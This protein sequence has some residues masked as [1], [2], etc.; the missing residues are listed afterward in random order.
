M[1]VTETMCSECGEKS[2]DP[3][4]CDYC[5][6]AR[7]GFHDTAVTSLWLEV[8]GEYSTIFSGERVGAGLASGNFQVSFRLDELREQYASR[9]IYYASV[10]GVVALSPECSADRLSAVTSSLKSQVYLLEEIHSATGAQV[11]SALADSVKAFVRKPLLRGTHGEHQVLIYA[12]NAGMTLE[13]LVDLS[14][15]Q[16]LFPQV[17][18]AFTAVLE[19]M[20]NLHNAGYL[21]LKL[22]P[23]N[24]RIFDQNAHDGFPRVFLRQAYAESRINEDLAQTYTGFDLGEEL[25]SEPIYDSGENAF[26]ERGSTLIEIAPI[27][28]TRSVE[29]DAQNDHDEDHHGDEVG[30]PFETEVYDKQSDSYPES[31]PIGHGIEDSDFEV[32]ATVSSYDY[33]AKSQDTSRLAALFDDVGEFYPRGMQHDVHAVVVGFS[34][35]EMMGRSYA[36]VDESADIFSLGM[37]LYYMVSGDVPPASVYTRHTPALPARNFRPGFPP[38]LQAVISRATRPHPQDRF[39]TLREF[40][41]SFNEACEV[42]EQRSNLNPYAAP[43]MRI[44][45]DTHI[46]IAKKRRNPTNQDHVF[47]AMA[48]DGLF[49]LIVVADGVSTASY[50]SGDLASGALTREAARAWDNMLPS[51]LM[52]ERMDDVALI[53]DILTNAN[54][55]I[56]DYVNAHYH[57]FFGSPHEVMGST[58]LVAIVRHGVV[59]LASLGDS[60]AYLQHGAGLE[61]LTIDHNLWTLSI[62]EGVPADNALAMPHGDALARCLGTFHVQQAQLVAVAPQPDFFR[63]TV[64]HGDTVLWTTDGLVDFGGA[65]MLVAEDNILAIL[66]SE[67]DPSLACLEMILLANRGGGGDNIGMAIARF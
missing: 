53:Q 48:D 52:D 20:E 34:A 26:Q 18:D 24:V 36:M 29:Y 6:A 62:L 64:T 58:A 43:A 16:L 10:S 9:R 30:F 21:H 3:N 28:A 49:G 38:G 8:G 44:A 40:R 11:K 60:R 67:P 35:P 41:R 59:T 1:P 65:N 66:L 12:D 31:N 61:Q 63:F 50:G 17:R 5:G 39:P 46:G 4:W 33:G 27:S 13:E 57:P 37:L 51:Y 22:A 19:L 2:S 47:S 25:S 54:Q 32:N 7:S 23:W 45:S 42:M 56:V 55:V 15:Q 14:H